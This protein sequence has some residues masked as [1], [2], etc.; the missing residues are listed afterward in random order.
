MHLKVYTD[1]RCVCQHESAACR[2][3]GQ[4]WVPGTGLGEAQLI[5]DDRFEGYK[6]YASEGSHST[7]AP[8]GHLQ[9]QLHAFVEQKYGYCEGTFIFLELTAWQPR[10]CQHA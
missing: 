1:H 8:R 6:V 9:R 3:P 7:F 10:L 5:W 4:F 2:G